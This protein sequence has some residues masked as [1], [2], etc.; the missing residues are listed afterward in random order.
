MNLDKL[1]E[2]PLDGI[3]RKQNIPNNISNGINIMK[4]CINSWF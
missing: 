2:I 3:D 1:D 4:S